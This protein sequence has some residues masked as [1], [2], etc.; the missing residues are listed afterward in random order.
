ML[1]KPKMLSVHT[2]LKYNL[3]RLLSCDCHC[4]VP[5]R[6]GGIRCGEIGCVK[7]KQKRTKPCIFNTLRRQESCC[8]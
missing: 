4:F 1:P 8:V 7:R 3:E 5:N 2:T 6:T